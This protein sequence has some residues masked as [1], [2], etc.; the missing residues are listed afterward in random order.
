MSSFE[1]DITAYAELFAKQIEA[2]S[3]QT[4]LDAGK[5]GEKAARET[6]LFKNNGP[7]RDATNFHITSKT[8][9]F[10]L[11]DKSYAQFLEFGNNQGGP[12]IYPRKAKALHF[13]INGEE[14]FVKKVRSHGPLP[15]M[16]NAGKI[17]EA[18][19]E[20]IWNKNIEKQIR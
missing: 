15:F 5:L 10:V 9:G 11:A 6:K 19:I 2:A 12:Y 16:D 17:V 13:F 14:V 4:L 18:A 8:S 7:L 20:E 1:I 3:I